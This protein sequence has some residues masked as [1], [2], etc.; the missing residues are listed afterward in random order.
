M[1]VT[2]TTVSFYMITA[3]TPTFGNSVLHLANVDSLIV[4]LCVGASNLFWLPVMGA[5]SDRVGRRPLLFACTILMLTTAYPTMLWLAGAPS[6]AR[7]LTVELWLSF[8]YGSY[9]GAMVVF[10]TEIMPI[11]VRTSGF[12]LAYSLA[13]AI[14]GGFTPAI[15]TYL[16]HVT[17]NRAVQGLWLSFAAACSLVAAMFARPQREAAATS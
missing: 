3:Y 5:L 11:D 9:N 17:A 15:S 14:F 10:L 6:F 7:L 1:M 13:T 2:M 16:I 8:L 12:A 4:T